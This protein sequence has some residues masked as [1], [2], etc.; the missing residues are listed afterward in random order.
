[1]KTKNKRYEELKRCEALARIV[2]ICEENDFI[3]Y[4]EL[5][6]WINENEIRLVYTLSNQRNRAFIKS[7]INS[8]YETKNDQCIKN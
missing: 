3:E 8:R 5:E 6:K 7:F 2:D 4:D 1:M